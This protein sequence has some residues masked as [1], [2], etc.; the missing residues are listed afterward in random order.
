MSG[1]TEAMTTRG[2]D[3]R[4]SRAVED[5]AHTENRIVLD[6]S[7]LQQY[8]RAH[9]Q[10]ILANLPEIPGWRTCWVSTTSGSDTPQMRM[11][12]GWEFVK[13]EDLPGWSTTK[14][15]SLSSSSYEGCIGIREMVAMKIPVELRNFYMK[16]AHDTLPAFEQ[17]KLK[18][19]ERAIAETISRMSGGA[20]R[21]I[22]GD[23]VYSE[24]VEA[25]ALKG[26]GAA[27]DRP[28]FD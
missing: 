7:R 23:Q 13:P 12:I 16:D 4:A 20:S 15:A 17:Q 5:R 6:D 8:R 3:T 28:M 25:T 19:D 22:P 11:E 1:K 26:H 21:V 24:D 10:P 2:S 18:D 14:V 27:N 9:E